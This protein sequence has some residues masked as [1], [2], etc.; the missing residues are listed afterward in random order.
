MLPATIDDLDGVRKECLRM[1]RK[2]ALLSAAASVVPVPFTDVAADVALLQQITPKISQKFGLSKEQI[3]EYNPQVAILIYDISKRLGT[4]MIGKYVTKELVI[5]ALKKIGVRIT[6]KSAA[7][8]VPLIGQAISA[9]LGYAGMRYIIHS[10]IN[11]CYR[12]AQ[13][14]LEA[15]P[16]G[17]AE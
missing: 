3:D 12:V 15:N 16:E 7:R 8:Y 10:H 14:V 6:A 1:A 9:A 13:A 4:K 2:R 5:Q 17:A 11:E